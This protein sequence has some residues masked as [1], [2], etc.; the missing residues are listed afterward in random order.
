MGLFV[1]STGEA[2]HEI[3]LQRG[4]RLYPDEPGAGGLRPTYVQGWV[5]HSSSIL[6]SYGV[7]VL[8][9]GPS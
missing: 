1:H 6:T 9:P 2:T 8:G 3:L 5:V 7:F 4:R